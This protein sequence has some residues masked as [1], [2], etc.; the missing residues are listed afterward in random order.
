MRATEP[1]PDRD[2]DP[3]ALASYV[4]STSIAS[5]PKTYGSDWDSWMNRPYTAESPYSLTPTE[6]IGGRRE[7]R[8][9]GRGYDEDDY[10][11]LNTDAIPAYRENDDYASA[12]NSD[13]DFDIDDYDI[14]DYDIDEARIDR[15]W[16][17]I[18]GVTGAILFVSVIIASLIL[19]GGDSGSVS[20]TVVSTEPTSS[21]APSPSP[22]AVAPTMP[23]MPAETVTTVT[24][25]PSPTVDAPVAQPLLPEPQAAPPA[26]AAPG[27][28]TYQVTGDRRLID[29]VTVIYTDHQGA[30]VTDINVALPWSKTVVLNP[31]VTL[32]SVTATSVA[33]KLNCSITDANGVLIAAQNNNSIIT[34]CTR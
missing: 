19:G 10:L 15:R 11:D 9:H 2:R 26:A 13:F 34:N 24:P 4:T 25:S 5:G 31:G 3:G 23:S 29:M 16:M 12:Q 27:T 21:A 1:S 22:Q 33:G 7:R 30:L 28:V 17:W 32:S 18:A 20:A 14:D 6:R 8:R